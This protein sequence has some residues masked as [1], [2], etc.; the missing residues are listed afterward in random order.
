MLRGDLKAQIESLSLTIETGMEAGNLKPLEVLATI[1]AYEK[2]FD[3]IKT[4][5]IKGSLNEADKHPDKEF[6]AYGVRFTKMEAGV[7]YDYSNCGHLDYN[8]ICNKIIALNGVKKDYEKQLQSL[9]SMTVIMSM[10]GELME[11]YPPAKRSTTT[12]KVNI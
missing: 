3:S 8:E 10:D 7:T 4:S 12:L 2:V 11:V 6:N 1:K 9:K 5:V